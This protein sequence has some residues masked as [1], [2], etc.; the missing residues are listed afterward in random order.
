MPAAFKICLSFYRFFSP[1]PPAGAG[2]PANAASPPLF[3][4]TEGF[5]EKEMSVSAIDERLV[6]EKS[7]VH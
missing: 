4:H 2:S 6:Y 5:S 3:R 7:W 1:Q